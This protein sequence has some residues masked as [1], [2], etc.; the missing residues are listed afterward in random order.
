MPVLKIQTFGEPSVSWSPAG[1]GGR[2]ENSKPLA[3][4]VYLA[5]SPKQSATR[6][7][8]IDLLWADDATERARHNLRQTLSYIRKRFGDEVLT[9]D[10]PV[11]TLT[12][13]YDCDRDRFLALAGSGDV[14]GAISAYTGDFLPHLGLPGGAEFEQ[15]ADLERGRLR[16]MFI[17]CAEAQARTALAAGRYRESLSLGRRV[18]ECDPFNLAA[19]R[20]ILEALTSAGDVFGAATEADR[21]EQFLQQEDIEPD[22][23]TQDA[24]RAAR[25]LS[26][27]RPA[28]D[29]GT[30]DTPRGIVTDLIGREREFDQLLSAWHRVSHGQGE[31]VHVAAPAGLGKSRL[32]HDLHLRLRRM[33]ARVALVRVNQGEQDVPFAAAADMAECLVR[34]LGG[35]TLSPAT[36][37]SLVALNPALSSTFDVAPDPSEGEEATRRRSL[38]LVELARNVAR[39]TPLALL[40]DDLHWADAGSLRLLATVTSRLREGRIL[41]VTTARPEGSGAVVSPTTSVLPLEPLS[42]SHVHAFLANIAKLPDE[43]WSG[44]FPSA[45]HRATQGS[46]LLLLET[47]QLALDRSALKVE[48]ELWHC[49]DPQALADLLREGSALERRISALPPDQVRVLALLAVAGTPLAFRQLERML[50]DAGGSDGA[51]ILS[52]LEASGFVRRLGATWVVAHDEIGATLLRI[53]PAEAVRAAHRAVGRELASS[54]GGSK[55]LYRVAAQHLKAAGDEAGV[56]AVFV[57]HVAAARR[58]GDRRA[59]RTIATEFFEGAWPDTLVR[60]AV[61]AVPWRHRQ[62]RRWVYTGAVAAGIIGVVAAGV[63]MMSA[64]HAAEVWLVGS[65]DGV[66]VSE[67]VY[68]DTWIASGP[69]VIRAG[70]RRGLSIPAQAIQAAHTARLPLADGGWLYTALSSDSGGWDIYAEAAN[71][72]RIRLTDHKSDDNLQDLSPDGR[73]MLFTSGRWR[74]NEHSALGF[75]DLT[76]K[77]VRRL[78]TGEETEMFGR[79]SPD[80]TRIAYQ[81]QADGDHAPALCVTDLRYSSPRCISY[82]GAVDLAPGGWTDPWHVT[83]MA[84]VDTGYVLGILDVAQWR[85]GPPIAF[86]LHWWFSPDGRY[87]VGLRAADAAHEPQWELLDVTAPSRRKVLDVG[88]A[89]ATKVE[90]ALVVPREALAS[91]RFLERIR[92]DPPAAPISVDLEH[93]FVVQ[94]EDN[95]GSQIEPPVVQWFVRDTMI[96]A[97]SEAGLL[98]PR[99]AGTTRVIADAGG[100]RSDSIEV[101]VGPSQVRRLLTDTW[102]RF[103]STRWVPFGEPRPKLGVLH[104]V[105]ALLPNGDSSFFSGV[106]SAETYAID[107]GL[108]LRTTVLVP[109]N[110]QQWQTAIVTVAA[111]DTVQLRRWDHRTGPLVVGMEQCAVGFPAG[112]LYPRTQRSSVMTGTMESLLPF[113]PRLRSGQ[114]VT[115]DVQILPDGRC[116]VAFDG[117]AVYLSQRRLRPSERVIIALTGQSVRAVVGFGPVEV[118]RGVRPGIRWLAAARAPAPS[119]SPASR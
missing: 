96:A 80:G 13:P 70:S 11:V 82:D 22:P 6:D 52:Q 54:A 61:A 17:R 74:A 48:N 104:G 78:S 87:A 31:H 50:H 33:G 4:L 8:L 3:L 15:W 83:Y 108:S 28:K 32:L 85:L 116:G 102:E 86:G 53:E 103:D 30:Q 47:L 72:R 23:S 7:E 9:T 43:A 100:W 59:T 39:E 49:T 77:A 45:L 79:W 10:R 67:P 81:R 21:L 25:Q 27:K 65:I 57:S 62:T 76:T 110:P 19:W 75:L 18:R 16:L 64:R 95:R 84:R 56:C 93:Q 63:F 14:E 94:G 101:T 113:P 92:I 105:R 91:R 97:I 20:L 46:P 41:L 34:L 99:R 107:R 88:A 66:P 98:Q 38:A 12:V 111:M 55:A 68:R 26:S 69:L 73:T 5:C 119:T 90:L 24:L 118:M 71:G 40:V 58:D 44:T 51:A 114:W 1:P 117:H 42:A 35:S 112:E 29:G 115:V 37:A 106:H 89:A 109:G 36:S 60:G 2:L